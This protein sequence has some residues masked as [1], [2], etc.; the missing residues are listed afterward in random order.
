MSTIDTT[1]YYLIQST[2]FPIKCL[3]VVNGSAVQLTPSPTTLAQYWYECWAFRPAGSSYAITSM[4]GGPSS[5]LGVTGDWG[6]P[7]DG[8]LAYG[9]CALPWQWQVFPLP[10]VSNVVSFGTDGQFGLGGLSP[11]WMT[12]ILSGQNQNYANVLKK[13]D[14]SLL[15]YWTLVKTAIKV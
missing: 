2:F 14:F 6:K 9:P 8:L 5:C 1:Y 10:G 13:N 15:K 7:D 4:S 12:W 11:W 3:T